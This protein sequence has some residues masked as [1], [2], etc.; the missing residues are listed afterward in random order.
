MALH[1][2]S[3]SFD[4]DARML[5]NFYHAN[6]T[7]GCLSFPTVMH[8]VAYKMYEQIDPEFSKQ[9]TRG[10]LNYIGDDPRKVMIMTGKRSKWSKVMQFGRRKSPLVQSDYKPGWSDEK[11]ERVIRKA[12]KTKLDQHPH[13]RG[14]LIDTGDQ[15]LLHTTSN[16]G[17]WGVCYHKNPKTNE[18]YTTGE[19]MLGKILM[20][21][22]SEYK[23]I[24]CYKDELRTVFS[25]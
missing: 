12:L 8:Y 18:R 14:V 21:L 3:D 20:E 4:E 7:I 1:F 17:K 5:S 15:D 6:I 2:N 23:D 22:R 9:F 11:H 24:D 25:I 19:N 10:S 13:I 16:G